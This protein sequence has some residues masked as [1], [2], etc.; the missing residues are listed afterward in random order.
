MRR[1]ADHRPAL[2]E[3][4]NCDQRLKAL[5]VSIAIIEVRGYAI[6]R[7]VLRVAAA[8]VDPQVP[9]GKPAQESGSSEATN[10]VATSGS[11]AI[12]SRVAAS[13]NSHATRGA[14]LTLFVPREWTPSVRPLKFARANA[15]RLRSPRLIWRRTS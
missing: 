12:D 13:T 9:I 14:S 5:F 3:K 11:A 2:G 15:L 1:C 7:R 4:Q 6:R 10:T 8:Q